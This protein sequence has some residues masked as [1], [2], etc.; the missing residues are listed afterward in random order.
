MSPPRLVLLLL[1]AQAASLGVF[2]S[3][4]LLTRIEL[5]DVSTDSLATQAPID[6]VV[7]VL[8]DALRED[9]VF[10]SPPR[11]PQLLQ[12]LDEAVGG[13][14]ARVENKVLNHRRLRFVSVRLLTT[15]GPSRR[16]LSL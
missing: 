15:T 1:A 7:I 6:R 10:A 14:T 13:R 2:L 16:C 8:V 4:F 5:P 11:M 9:F 12:L 3:G